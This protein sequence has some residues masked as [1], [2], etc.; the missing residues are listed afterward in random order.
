MRLLQPRSSLPSDFE[1]H[2]VAS[3]PV[4][5]R[6]FFDERGILLET[7]TERLACPSCK[8]GLRKGSKNHIVTH[9]C[10]NTD[11]HR[12]PKS[13]SERAGGFLQ[14]TG[15]GVYLELGMI[16]K[17]VYYVLV[18]AEDILRNGRGR[19]F[20]GNLIG[21]ED[22]E[23]EMDE[24]KM[25]ACKDGKGHPIEGVWVF[26]AVCRRTGRFVAE[27]LIRGY[28]E[29]GG[30]WAKGP[31]AVFNVMFEN[32]SS[33]EDSEDNVGR[34]LALRM[35]LP[36][37][38]GGRGFPKLA[39]AK[40][41]SPAAI[42]EAVIPEGCYGIL[43]ID[44]IQNL[45]KEGK[46]PRKQGILFYS[47]MR[48]AASLV[49]NKAERVVVGYV[50]AISMV[51]LQYLLWNSPQ[52]RMYLSILRVKTVYRRSTRGRPLEVFK[53][54]EEQLLMSEMGGHGR[55][56]EGLETACGK[57][58]GESVTAEDQ[59][60]R[61]QVLFGACYSI[62]NSLYENML[63]ISRMR[64]AFE[65]LIL[66]AL[67]L[68]PV[69]DREEMVGS[70]K[71]EEFPLARLRQ[72]EDE[73]EVIELPFFWLRCAH[74]Q[75][76]KKEL[77]KHVLLGFAPLFQEEKDRSLDGREFEEYGLRL[78]VLRSYFRE[79]G[80]NVK[81]S[82]LHRG[83]K[84]HGDA[85]FLVENRHLSVKKFGHKAARDSLKFGCQKP[86]ADEQISEMKGRK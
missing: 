19:K 36:Q 45:L 65:Q 57:H 37:K 72:L 44:G 62:I 71:V 49:C 58:R 29:C 82:E 20:G 31:A 42:I 8:S 17:L 32:G 2:S 67:R 6:Q 76:W 27:P 35:L 5:S 26:V 13:F 1:I 79:D 66:K 12:D 16:I 84:L 7:G 11:C 23:V 39:S 86:C 25:R 40:L 41:P 28:S 52:K 70:V 43:C 30:F 80:E 83:A 48:E 51:P 46:D 10:R 3:D 33:I 9:R 56:L 54:R 55:E 78:R 73:S 18:M 59:E 38:P 47:I 60:R 75:G 14:K 68:D 15:G 74:K 21:G 22:E 34:L 50:T 81:Y 4:K 24:I 61:A 53:E 85:D 69:W 63:F 77:L 64:K